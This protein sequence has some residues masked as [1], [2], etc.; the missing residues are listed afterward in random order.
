MIAGF[1]SLGFRPFFFGAGLWACIAMGVW[2]VVLG[3]PAH[4]SKAD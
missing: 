3:G 4:L 2:L 1:L